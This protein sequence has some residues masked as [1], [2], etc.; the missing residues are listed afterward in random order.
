MKTLLCIL[1]AALLLA[2][3]ASPSGPERARTWKATTKTDQ[4]T[5]VTTKTLEMNVG[6]GAYNYSKMTFF[7]GS[8]TNSVVVGVKSLSNFPVGT[9]QLRV[10]EN[11]AITISP[12]ETPVLFTPSIPL[13]TNHAMASVQSETMLN[14]TQ[15]MSPFTATGGDKAQQIIKELVHGKTLRF[16]TIG[17]NAAA[18]STGWAALD[19]SFLSGLKSLGIDPANY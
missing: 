17:A 13:S 4:F 16:R 10:D 18:S 2:G 5:D 3:C 14:M 8:R 11:P 9:V 12:A 19:E 15:I 1:T 6:G 7:V